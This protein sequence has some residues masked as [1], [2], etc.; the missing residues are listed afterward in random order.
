MTVSFDFGVELLSLKILQFVFDLP[1]SLLVTRQNK[2]RGNISKRLLTFIH[3]Q[4][5]RSN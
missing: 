5:Y 2:L 1:R 4:T 3:S